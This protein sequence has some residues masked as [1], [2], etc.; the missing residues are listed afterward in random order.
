M[1]YIEEDCADTL[2]NDILE[3]RSIYDNIILK[4][5][6]KQKCGM[7]TYALQMMKHMDKYFN[8]NKR[9]R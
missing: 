8:E 1:N 5:I 6:G 3:R 4:V 9:N 2:L 7:S